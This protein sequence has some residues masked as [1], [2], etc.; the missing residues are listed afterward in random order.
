MG[1]SG[2][3]WA[4]VGSSGLKWAQV[5]SSGL[6]WAQVGSSGLKWAQVG[7]SGLKWAQVGSSGLNALLLVPN[8]AITL[9]ES[10]LLF[11]GPF[12]G[13]GVARTTKRNISRTGTRLTGL[14][15]YLSG[16]NLVYCN[17][18]SQEVSGS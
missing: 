12:M 6:K 18:L 9:I 3:K 11:V 2:L 15:G 5:G 7:S 4:Q 13:M 10:D 1:S 8:K 17:T 14:I 16:S